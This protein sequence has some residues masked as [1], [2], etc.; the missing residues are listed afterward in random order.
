MNRCSRNI[1]DMTTCTD[2]RVVGCLLITH[3]PVKAE[4]LRQP[5]LNG[6]PLIITVASRGRQ[7]V[8]D[9]SRESVGVVEGQTVSEALSQCSDAITL[10]ADPVYLSELNDGL[11]AALCDA[12][13]QV[14]TA[15]TLR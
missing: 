15:S 3:L 12:V 9:A 6:L 2:V 1:G 14:E 4:L 7:V 10:P 13:P 11:L 8:L 5:Q